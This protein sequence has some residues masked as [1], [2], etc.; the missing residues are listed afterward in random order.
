MLL[1]LIK[2]KNWNDFN[3]NPPNRELIIALTFRQQ[4]YQRYFIDQIS[5][6]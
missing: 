6:F 5:W 2:G 4:N 1:S 3:L